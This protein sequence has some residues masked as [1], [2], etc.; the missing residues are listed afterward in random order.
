MF[1]RRFWLDALERAIRAFFA[2]LGGTLTATAI[3]DLDA[4][5][6]QSLLGAGVAALVSLCFSIGATR[7]TDSI[8][9]ASLVPPT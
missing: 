1:T 2:A 7:Q 6:K 3:T 8:S 5:W 4:T 9:P